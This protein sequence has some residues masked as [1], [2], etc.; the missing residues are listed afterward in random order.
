AQ[1]F[2]AVEKLAVDAAVVAAHL[3]LGAELGDDFAVDLDAAGE[4]H[5]LSS[6]AG[7]DASFSQNFLQ[8][9]GVAGTLLE[10]RGR[11]FFAI[12]CLFFFGFFF[13]LVVVVFALF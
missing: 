1:A 2:G 12:G 8:T 5:L 6:A 3:C 4:D 10:G 9:L 11:V 7:G 13:V